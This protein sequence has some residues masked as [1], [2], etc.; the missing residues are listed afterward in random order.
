MMTGDRLQNLL[1]ASYAKLAAKAGFMYDVY[2]FDEPIAVTDELYKIA[3]IPVALAAEKKFAIPNK[4][5]T[6]TWYCYADGRILQPRDILKGP[7]G[8]FYIG[9]MQPN[10]P[11]QAV[12]T[13]HVISIGRGTY[14]GGDQTVEFYATGIPVFMQFKREDI[15]RS[16]YAA[17]MGQAITHWTTYIPLPEG[18]LKQ[19]DV[20]QDEEGIR[21]IVDAPDFTSIGYVAH[22]RLI[23]I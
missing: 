19:D 7:A 20:V 22:L 11:I 13:N 4:Y 3:R 8:T 16:E 9:D 15:K 2:R 5:Q 21:Y 14:D 17:T 10:L 12:E 18:M 6:A 23:T 1:Y